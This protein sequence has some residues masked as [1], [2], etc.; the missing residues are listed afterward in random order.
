LIIPNYDGTKIPHD[1]P[2]SKSMLAMKS[3]DFEKINN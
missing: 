1:N 3:A 2:Q